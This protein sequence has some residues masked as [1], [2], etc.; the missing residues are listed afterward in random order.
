[1]DGQCL[2]PNTNWLKNLTGL[3]LTVWLKSI[4]NVKISRY[5]V[6]CFVNDGYFSSNFREPETGL[7]SEVVSGQMS[8]H[9]NNQTRQMLNGILFNGSSNV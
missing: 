6:I 1:M 7:A 3:I 8:R 4:K 9:L 2:L 5:T